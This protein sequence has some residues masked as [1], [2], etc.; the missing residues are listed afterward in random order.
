MYKK[1]YTFINKR[2]L[3]NGQAHKVKQTESKHSM[4]SIWME[5]TG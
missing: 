2:W 5:E 3:E 4:W 1:V